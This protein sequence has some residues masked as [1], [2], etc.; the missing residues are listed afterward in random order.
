[1]ELFVNGKILCQKLAWFT[2]EY[3]FLR[4]YYGICLTIENGW[5]EY[6]SINRRIESSGTN[7]GMQ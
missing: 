7:Q 4:E 1:M 6:L 5:R 2:Y 3:P